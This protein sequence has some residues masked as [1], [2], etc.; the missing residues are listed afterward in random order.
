MRNLSIFFLLSLIFGC[1]TYEVYYTQNSDEGIFTWS[2]INDFQYDFWFIDS[3]T[4]IAMGKDPIHLGENSIYLYRYSLG[5]D[6]GLPPSNGWEGE[7][8]CSP[9]TMVYVY[10]S[11]INELAYLKHLSWSSDKFLSYDRKKAGLAFYYWNSGVYSTNIHDIDSVTPISTNVKLNIEEF[12][13]LFNG[14]YVSPVKVSIQSLYTQ[15][16]DVV[17]IYQDAAYMWFPRGNQEGVEI[18]F[19]PIDNSE[20]VSNISQFRLNSSNDF[21]FAGT[22]DPSNN[23][24]AGL[25]SDWKSYSAAI[26]RY[27]GNNVSNIDQITNFLKTN[28]GIL[29]SIEDLKNRAIIFH[30]T[31]LQPNEKREFWYYRVMMG[32]PY[33]STNF[34]MIEWKRKIVEEINFFRRNEKG[35]TKG[36]EGSEFKKLEE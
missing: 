34:S 36:L 21:Y 23:I 5:G 27:I 22:Y 12:N 18:I 2:S 30:I 14:F 29:P 33:I 31:S 25:Y 7:F 24:I 15:N 3:K 16:V 17:Y 20:N 8:F 28:S 13:Y 32:F 6:N 26:T 19:F 1:I 10:N 35:L 11:N 9:D 4:K